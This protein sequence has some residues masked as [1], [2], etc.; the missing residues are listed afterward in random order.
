MRLAAIDIGSNSIHMIVVDTLRGDAF[1]VVDREKQ[2]VKLGEG[3]FREHRLSERALQ[4]GL[5]A[6]RRFVKLA[7]SL[8]VEEIFAVATSATR[9]AE[10]GGEFLSAVGQATG[11]E[12]RIISGHEEARL[13]YRAVESALGLG[14]KTLVIDIG[15]GSV[16]LVA[17]DGQ[18]VELNESLQLG[19]QRLRDVVGDGPL[20]AP[21]LERLRKAIRKPLG[22]TARKAR[23]LG[24]Q[25]FVGTS[26]TIRA[27]EQASRRAAGGDGRR[28]GTAVIPL[29]AVRE[30]ARELA[31]LEAATRAARP[32]VPAERADTIHLGAVL[33]VELLEAAGA[34]ELTVCDASLREGLIL[35]YLDRRRHGTAQLLLQ[36]DVRH[37]SVQRLAHRYWQ[38]LA[39]PQH[40]AEL[41]LAL[42]DETAERHGLGVPE[43]DLLEF[44]A[45]LFGIGQHIA[46]K[47]YQRHSAYIIENTELHGFSHEETELLA[48]IVR[49][50]RKDGPKD[51]ELADLGKRRARVVR[52][53]S[54][55]LGFAVALDRGHSQVVRSLCCEERGGVLW[56]RLTGTGDLE[57]ELWAAHRQAPTL[58]AALKLPVE[59]ELCVPSDEDAG[60]GAGRLTSL[61]PARLSSPP[62]APS[63][64]PPAR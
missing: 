53:L 32:G 1:E 16:E 63:V 60:D 42:F 19:V 51:S 11:V 40:V 7:E 8:G 57:L 14:G 31:P 4:A 55:M 15:G 28:T 6:L 41:A 24:I 34:S 20:G 9:E 38:E 43:R 36:A 52:L 58:G 49:H 56:I 44:S 22:R 26:G 10:N 46:F 39:R 29:A 3:A 47:S 5:D 59:I 25:R 45:L 54:A 23:A 62:A 27:L 64:T 18:R 33:L 35:D 12:P 50:H 2:M 30:L 13:I 37:R 48:R 21:E 61:P 17:G